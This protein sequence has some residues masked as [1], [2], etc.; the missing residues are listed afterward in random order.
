[1]SIH[2]HPVGLNALTQNSNVIGTGWGKD[3][4]DGLETEGMCYVARYLK[5]GGCYTLG[6]SHFVKHTNN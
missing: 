3:G 6:G 2:I 1:M 4:W 5:G